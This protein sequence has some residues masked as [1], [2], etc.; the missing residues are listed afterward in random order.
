MLQS[1]YA[2][3]FCLV[4][5]V[6]FKPWSVTVWWEEWKQGQA[7][8]RGS[9]TETQT[10]GVLEGSFCLFL[11]A[12]FALYWKAATSKTWQLHIACKNEQQTTQWGVD[13]AYHPSKA[14]RTSLLGCLSREE[15]PASGLFGLGYGP[16]LHW[17]LSADSLTFLCVCV[18]SL[19]IFS[20]I[21]PFE[22]PTC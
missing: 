4:L 14:P 2:A 18:V 22:F 6:G 11:L 13:D 1:F 19:L 12:H 20:G 8:N 16:S 17:L 10:S 5:A 9:R 21:F 15:V 3:L 7:E